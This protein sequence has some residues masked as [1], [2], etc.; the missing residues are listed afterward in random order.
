[1]LVNLYYSYDKLN[2]TK[3]ERIQRSF[4]ITGFITTPLWKKKNLKTDKLV[5][6]SLKVQRSIIL[7][8]I[9]KVCQE[10][11]TES[12]DGER[13]DVKVDSDGFMK[14]DIYQKSPNESFDGSESSVIPVKRH[15]ARL[16]QSKRAFLEK[17]RARKEW[18][19]LISYKNISFQP[20]KKIQRQVAKEVARNQL[21]ALG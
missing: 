1:M 4:A 8:E 11:D 14:I 19:D 12:G 18:K 6:R 7:N 10:P 3:T 20:Q 13:N 21:R 15:Q 9:Q 16:S 2:K 5:V 17:S